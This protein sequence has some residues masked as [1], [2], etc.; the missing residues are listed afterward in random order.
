MELFT[1]SIKNPWNRVFL[2]DKAIYNEIAPLNPDCVFHLPL[3]TNVRQKDELICSAPS[4]M[5]RKFTHELS[6]IGSLYTEK[7]AYDRISGLSPYQTGY[8][9]GLMEA[10]LKVYGYYFIEEVLSDTLVE[11]FK[12]HF[13]Y[14]YHFPMESFLTD[15]T[16]L[17][18]LYIGTKITVME[19]D[20]IMKRLSERFPTTV[21]TG[22][23]TTAY[24]KLINKG[25]A[26]T[27]TEMPLIF[28]NSG[29]N[30]NITAKSIRSGLPL[31]IWDILGS[32]GFCLTNY[33]AE[34]PELLSIGTHL[35]AYTSLEELE[36]KVAYY[37]VHPNEAKEIA[38]T[39]YEEVKHNHTYPIRLAQMLSIAFKLT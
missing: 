14:F 26:K 22:S 4:E 37:L 21:Y 2:F 19:R 33:Q 36:E 28:H 31:R 15:K 13:P 35:D 39:G 25:F 7:C 6:F 20:R 17:A 32:G 12:E 1:T 23:D 29:I 8:L 16:T 27:L 38:M 10:Q 18:Q 30:L 34:L 5:H 3:A 11:E 24:P 9:N